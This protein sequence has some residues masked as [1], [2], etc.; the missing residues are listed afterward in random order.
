MRDRYQYACK[1]SA[2]HVSRELL[3]SL[4][5]MYQAELWNFQL[6]VVVTFGIAGDSPEESPYQSHYTPNCLL[7]LDLHLFF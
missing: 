4:M 3:D 6:V 5:G 7:P 1:H 2:P